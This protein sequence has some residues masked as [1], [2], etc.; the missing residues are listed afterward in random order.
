[1]IVLILCNIKIG[2]NR[3]NLAQFFLFAAELFWIKSQELNASIYM[4][5]SC[6]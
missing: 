1:M 6:Y 3:L 2:T 5:F 4:L